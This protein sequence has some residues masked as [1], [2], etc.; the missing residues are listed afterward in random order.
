MQKGTVSFTVKYDQPMIN[1][2]RKAKLETKNKRSIIVCQLFPNN[3]E[4]NFIL[5]SVLFCVWNFWPVVNISAI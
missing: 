1:L 3:D 5:V 4:F 2:H